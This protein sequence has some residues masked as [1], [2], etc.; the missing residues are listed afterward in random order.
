[1]TNISHQDNT[2]QELHGTQTKYF[3]YGG[4]P[5]LLVEVL[6]SHTPHVWLDSSG[7]VI[8]LTTHNTHKGQTDRQ[9]SMLPAGIEPVILASE[10][11]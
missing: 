5:K 10:Q 11:P 8:G 6:R 4:S 9:T 1:M 3:F 7:L 2:C